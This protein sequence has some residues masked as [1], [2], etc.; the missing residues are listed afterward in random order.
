MHT[1]GK[2]RKMAGLQTNSGKAMPQPSLE[3]EDLSKLLIVVGDQQDRDAFQSLFRHFAPRLKSFAQTCPAISANADELVQE[4]MIKVWRK[5]HTYNS[6]K[7]AANTW[8]FTIA[9]NT[10][11]DM[12]RQ[13]N[14]IPA[15]VDADD[16]WLEAEDG[17]PISELHQH[18]AEKQIKQGLSTLAVEQHQ[19]LSKV[20]LEGKSHSETAEELGLPLGTVKGRIRLAMKKLKITL[21]S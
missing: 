8:I 17:E 20:Y 14:K 9:R 13:V 21:G 4:V 10:R 15:S 5:A 16:V 12:L 6:D 19:V 18:Q 7:A 2:A 3:P 11:I 1:D